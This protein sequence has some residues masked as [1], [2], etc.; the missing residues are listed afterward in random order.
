MALFILN[1]TPQ[2]PYS[3]KPNEQQ[4]SYIYMSSVPSISKRCTDAEKRLQVEQ[5]LLTKGKPKYLGTINKNVMVS[6]VGK[7]WNPATCGSKVEDQHNNLY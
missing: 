7:Q 2:N 4:A 5:E 6:T 1:A 3:E